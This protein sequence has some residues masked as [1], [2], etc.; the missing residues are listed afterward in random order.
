[1]ASLFALLDDLLNAESRSSFIELCIVAR[2]L[3]RR[4]TQARGILRMMQITA[5]QRGAPIPSEVRAL[6][7][8]FESQSWGSSD[9]EKLS[10]GY[11]NFATILR[12]DESS[13]DYEMDSF[14][15]KWD[16]LQV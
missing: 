4:W 10:S 5:E 7:A 2:A 11:P 15:A 9:R 12:P 1:M 16:K 3:A 8:D 14:L 13:E 6:L